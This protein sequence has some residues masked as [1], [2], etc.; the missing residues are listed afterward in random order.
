[1][2]IVKNLTL[3][4]LRKESFTRKIKKKIN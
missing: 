2:K 1:L 4:Y 3:N